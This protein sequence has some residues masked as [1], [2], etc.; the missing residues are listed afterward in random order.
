MDKELQPYV[1]KG[2]AVALL[3]AVLLYQLLPPVLPVIENQQQQYFFVLFLPAL[4]IFLLTLIAG[5]YRFVSRGID[6]LR[7]DEDRFLV[8]TL[9]CLTNSLEQGFVFVAFCLTWFALDRAQAEQLVPTI[10]TIFIFARIIFYL[11][12]LKGTMLRSPG[13]ALTYFVNVYLFVQILFSF[14]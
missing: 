4:W 2:A 14:S 3:L 7:G 10:A 13:M 6:P 11:G 1:Y 9:R 8:V 5:N 12:Y